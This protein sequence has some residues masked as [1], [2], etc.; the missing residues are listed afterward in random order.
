MDTVTDLRRE[1]RIK[2]VLPVLFL[3]GR[4]TTQNVSA[5]GLFLETEYALP[6][7]EEVDLIIEFD[8]HAGGP[9]QVKCA[10][11]ILRMVENGGSRGVA[12]AL[13]WKAT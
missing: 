7:G 12:A 2:A 4:G 13:R 6:L 11:T 10:A 8:H 1:E 3:G 5:S 9:L